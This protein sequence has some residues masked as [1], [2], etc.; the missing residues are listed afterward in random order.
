M[1]ID[2][3]KDTDMGGFA[4]KNLE[5]EEVDSLFQFSEPMGSKYIG[6]WTTKREFTIT[7]V[8]WP[9]AGP[10]QVGEPFGMRASTRTDMARSIRVAPPLLSQASQSTSPKM[11]GSFGPAVISVVSFVAVPNHLTIG[12]SI[13]GNGVAM[14]L[15]FNRD[16][17]FA[18]YEP[19]RTPLSA[20]QMSTFLRFSAT[21][22][23]RFTGTFTDRKTLR[24]DILDA[25]G[26]LANIG[27]FYVTFVADESYGLRN[28][29]AASAPSQAVS[30]ALSGD[31]GPSNVVISS[32]VAADPDNADI[33]YSRQD[34][35]IITF[36]RDT[37][38]GRGRISTSL[39]NF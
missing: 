23:A 32:F 14:I 2:F 16:T 12:D 27:D 38:L 8:D 28:Y 19:S 29:P 17:N 31:F 39:Q 11:I 9:G 3:D 35:L 34:I 10:P 1:V 33:F 7:I 15:N 37:N 26:G 22:G 21:P 24:F 5:K 20:S 18:G 13:Y 36:N 6:R 25:A 4:T 30:P